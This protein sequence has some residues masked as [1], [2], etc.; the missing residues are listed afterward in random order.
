MYDG[1]VV[2]QTRTKTTVSTAKSHNYCAQQG[3]IF[4]RDGSQILILCWVSD[5][6]VRKCFIDFGATD[7]PAS[8]FTNSDVSACRTTLL[9]GL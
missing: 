4:A 8:R 9:Y 1:K 2:T 6:A 5:G 7:G 3:F